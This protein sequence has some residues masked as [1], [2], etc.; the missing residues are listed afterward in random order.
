MK[1]RSTPRD[2]R[3]SF[4]NR[5]ADEVERLITGPNVYICNECILMCNGILE[6]EM[7]RSTLSTV[8]HLPLPT[9]IKEAL[10]EYVIGQ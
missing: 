9:E 4:C 1:K 6:E 8:E 10:D 7:S 5:N 3:C 2:L